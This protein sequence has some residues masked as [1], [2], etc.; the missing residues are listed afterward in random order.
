MKS[1]KFLKI[2]VGEPIVQF[3]ASTHV[4]NIGLKLN[5]GTAVFGFRFYRYSDENI[6][7]WRFM[8]GHK[9]WKRLAP[10]HINTPIGG[11]LYHQIALG[12]PVDVPENQV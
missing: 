1:M 11:M 8:F 2:P 10:M 9:F 4:F 5:C 7:R 3:T 6:I 12:K